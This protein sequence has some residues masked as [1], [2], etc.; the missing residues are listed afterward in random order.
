MYSYKNDP[1]SCALAILCEGTVF[2]QNPLYRACF[3]EGFFP[4]PAEEGQE[5]TFHR[6]PFPY[7][8]TN[9]PLTEEGKTYSLFAALP[10]AEGDGREVILARFRRMVTDVWTLFSRATARPPLRTVTVGML[11]HTV[12]LLAEEEFS[13][14]FHLS[15]DT[16]AIDEYVRV[17]E[18]G[19]LM[20]LGIL[21]PPMLTD[22]GA[23]ICLRQL[24]DGWQM[25]LRGG[26]P[27]A[28]PF[29]RSLAARLCQSSGALLRF[30]EEGFSLFFPMHRPKA[31]SLRTPN[32][33]R[34][35][36]CLHLGSYLGE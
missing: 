2:Y 7:V 34:I 19:L 29:L 24:V 18:R 13:L 23:G 6:H 3:G 35:A 32:P 10:F 27:P 14:S 9:I 36:H 21:L 11:F 20:A 8:A 15:G 30:E 33:R 1:C 16:P 28:L 17:D 22:G 25:L 5:P 4:P 31:L 26:R 12:C